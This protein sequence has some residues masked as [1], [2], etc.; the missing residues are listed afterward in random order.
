MRSNSQPAIEITLGL[1]AVCAAPA[2]ASSIGAEAYVSVAAA[3][4]DTYVPA[5]LVTG[6]TSA[7]AAAT[8]GGS[9]GP[10]CG[11]GSLYYGAT[12]LGMALRQPILPVGCSGPRQPEAASQYLPKP[13]RLAEPTHLDCSPIRSTLLRSGLGSSSRALPSLPSTLTDTWRAAPRSTAKSS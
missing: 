7:T 12:T 11:L 1:I 10:N 13:I 9:G 4:S 6:P 3:C 5:V 8:N 2:G